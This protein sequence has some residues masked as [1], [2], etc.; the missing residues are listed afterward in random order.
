MQNIPPVVL[1][2]IFSKPTLKRV[3][4]CFDLPFS[5]SPTR[6]S[7]KERFIENRRVDLFRNSSLGL[8]SLCCQQSSPLAKPNTNQQQQ[9]NPSIVQTPFMN[10][11]WQFNPEETPRLANW[12]K[13]MEAARSLQNI[14]RSSLVSC[15]L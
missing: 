7:R 13:S 15:S 8:L 2:L 11:Q 1:T 4:K 14:T 12:P 3:L 5:P 6:G 9:S 10:Q